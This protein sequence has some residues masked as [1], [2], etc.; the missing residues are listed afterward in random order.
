VTSTLQPCASRTA[1]FV[2][3]TAIPGEYSRQAKKREVAS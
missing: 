3:Q 2:C 1:G